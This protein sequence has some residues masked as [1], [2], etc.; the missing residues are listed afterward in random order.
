MFRH[1]YRSRSAGVNCQQKVSKG[2]FSLILYSVV[3]IVVNVML[4]MFLFLMG[5]YAAIGKYAT[6][7]INRCWKVKK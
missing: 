2:A 4:G 5:I 3:L 7:F 1:V 6:G